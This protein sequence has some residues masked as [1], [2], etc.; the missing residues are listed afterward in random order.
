MKRKVTWLLKKDRSCSRCGTVFPKG[1]SVGKFLRHI[2]ACVM[3][4]VYANCCVR[5]PKDCPKDGKYGD[6][7]EDYSCLLMPMPPEFGEAES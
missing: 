5:H 7:T 4:C 6:A 2:Q 3:K 1:S